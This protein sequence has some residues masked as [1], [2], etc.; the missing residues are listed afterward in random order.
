MKHTSEDIQD[1]IWL[2]NLV[3]HDGERHHT[4]D[5]Y[6]AQALQSSALGNQTG[7]TED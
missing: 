2:V 6:L 1:A 5:R 3:E 4:R 7:R